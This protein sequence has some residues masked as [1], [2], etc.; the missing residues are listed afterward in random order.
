MPD[1]SSLPTQVLPSKTDYELTNLGI[2]AF[3]DLRTQEFHS[4]IPQF[5]NP[6]IPNLFKMGTA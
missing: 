6:S 2:Q 4:L 1:L 5:L 3:W